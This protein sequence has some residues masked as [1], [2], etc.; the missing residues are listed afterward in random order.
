MHL[1]KHLL[2]SHESSG[3]ENEACPQR[4]GQFCYAGLLEVLGNDLFSV[5]VFWNEALAELCAGLKICSSSFR[6]RM[7]FLTGMLWPTVC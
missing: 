1:G 7:L 3:R 2:A 6:K 4:A 5:R